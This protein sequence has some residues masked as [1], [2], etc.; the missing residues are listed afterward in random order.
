MTD[1]GLIEQ[2]TAKVSG[3]TVYFPTWVRPGTNN[4]GRPYLV[5]LGADKLAC[6]IADAVNEY[7]KPSGEA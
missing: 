1:T 6:I 7:L 4:H 5:F 2:T 3:D